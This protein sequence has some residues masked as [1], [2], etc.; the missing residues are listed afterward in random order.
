MLATI[1]NT[2]RNENWHYFNKFIYHDIFQIKNMKELRLMLD[3]TDPDISI[4][5][6]K[7]VMVSLTEVFKDTVPGYRIRPLSDKEKNTKV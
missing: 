5:I 1:V 6:R 7:L 3:E 2:P 4:T